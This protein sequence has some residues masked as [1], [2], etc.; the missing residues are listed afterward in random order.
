MAGDTKKALQRMQK[1]LDREQIQ[2]DL[3][4]PGKKPVPVRNSDRADL[5]LDAYASRVMNPPKKKSGCGLF[6]VL[7]L[8]ALVLGLGWLVLKLGGVIA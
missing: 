7:C 2:A 3:E 4:S 5:D 1:R 8:L 6:W